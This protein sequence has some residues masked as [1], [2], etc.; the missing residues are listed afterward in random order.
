MGSKKRKKLAGNFRG[1]KQ[2]AKEE[3]SRQAGYRR[4]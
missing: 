3:I 1:N 4:K 2:A